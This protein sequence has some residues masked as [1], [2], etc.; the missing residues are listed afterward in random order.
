MMSKFGWLDSV[1]LAEYGLDPSWAT[2]GVRPRGTL[3]SGTS[4]RNVEIKSV[5]VLLAVRRH[6]L[7]VR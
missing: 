3:K 4:V 7:T 5:F 1:P 2:K 6:R